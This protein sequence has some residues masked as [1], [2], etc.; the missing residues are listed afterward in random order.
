MGLGIVAALLLLFP[1]VQD[2]ATEKARKKL[3]NMRISLE[4]NDVPLAEPIDYFRDMT[5]LNIVVDMEV[6]SRGDLPVSI[7]VKNLTA[8]SA[9]SLLLRPLGLTWTWKEGVIFVTTKEKGHDLVSLRIYDV[10]DLLFPLRDFPGV[11]LQLNDTSVGTTFTDDEDEAGE[12]LPLEEILQAHTGGKSWDENSKAS[13]SLANGLLVVR[14]SAEVHL[15]IRR[16]LGKLR[17][18]R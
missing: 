17:R 5:G 1:G 14:Q 16:L 18:N 8:R 4:F 7:V 2:D 15:Q 9:L 6:T 3:R 13:I 10:R 12:V 11:E